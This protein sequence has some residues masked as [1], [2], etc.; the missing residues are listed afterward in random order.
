MGVYRVMMTRDKEELMNHGTRTKDWDFNTSKIVET[1]MLLELIVTLRKITCINQGNVD[2]H[3][4]NREI[5]RIIGSTP[6]VAS[7]FDQE[8]TAEIKSI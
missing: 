6:N 3:L 7:I 1:V 4:D 2:S 8:S 5:C